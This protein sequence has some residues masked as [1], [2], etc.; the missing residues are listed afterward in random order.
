MKVYSDDKKMNHLSDIALASSF[1]E[2]I[3]FIDIPR[4]KPSIFPDL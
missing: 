4:R 2:K 1:T 3:H